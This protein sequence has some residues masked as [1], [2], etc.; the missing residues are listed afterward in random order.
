MS[1]ATY[2][3]TYRA[4]REGQRRR[5]L[6]A[7][8]AWLAGF[9]QIDVVVVEQ[10][11]APTELALPRQRCQAL[12]AYNP[13]PFNKSWGLNVGFRAAQTQWLGFGDADVIVGDAL[14]Q[15]FEL[16]RQGLLAVKP[17][18]RLIDLDEEE[19]KPVRAGNFTRVP[20]R[21]PRA[22][23]SREGIGEHVVFAG[24]SFV[25]HR[26]AFAALGGWD[27]RFLGWGGEDDALSYRIERSR[28]ACTELDVS[29]AMHLWHARPREATFDQPSYA[30]NRQLLDDY[31]RYADAQLDRLAE[32]QM[33]VLGRR[34]KYRPLSA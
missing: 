29:P 32:V 31:R 14:W 2:I 22:A 6:E 20:A 15:S 30:A 27:E 25:I 3:L 23:P 5:N 17:Y 4:D 13:G 33:Q 19:S 1:Q 16:L 26:H 11:V 7:V 24:G 34:E 8:L 9:A 21:D 28:I 10:D 18:R 12:F